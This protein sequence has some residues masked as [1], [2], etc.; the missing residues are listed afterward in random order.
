MIVNSGSGTTYYDLLPPT[1][2]PGNDDFDGW[3]FGTFAPT[4]TFTLEGF[5]NKTYKCDTDNVLNGSLYYRVYLSTDPAPAFIGPITTTTVIYE[6]DDPSCFIGT[7]RRQTWED[8]SLTTNII[9]GLADGHYYFEVYTTAEYTFGAVGTGTHVSD[10]T[11][12]YYRASF[13]M[14]DDTIPP[15]ITCPANININNDGGLCSAVVTYSVTST[16]NCAG[17]TISQT[18]GIASGGT[19]PVGTT[20][21]TFVVTDVDGNTAT[22]SFDVTVNDTEDPTISCPADVVVSTDVGSCDVTGVALGSPTTSDN[23][24]GETTANDAPATFPIGLTIVTWT[25][26]DA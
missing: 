22:C 23:C 7:D 11:G 16:D 10:N 13:M 17:E 12:S 20:T 9:G 26:T 15:T 1:P 3:D 6:E 21:N 5:Q 25:V 8:S 18:A 2:A 14:C 24:P 19:F 4:Q